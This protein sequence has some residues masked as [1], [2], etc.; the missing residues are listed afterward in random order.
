MLKEILNEFNFDGNIVNIESNNQGNINTTYV[1]TVDNGRKYLLQK[2]N[3]SVFTN[4]YVVMNN[5][6]IVTDTMEKSKVI[7]KPLKVIS[8]KKNSPLAVIKNGHGEMEYYRC[9]EYIENCISYDTVKDA[10]NPNDI[11]YNAG[12][13]FGLFHKSLTSLNSSNDVIQETIP[14]FHNTPKRFDD[15]INS[16]K[17]NIVGRSLDYPRETVDLIVKSEECFSI[18]KK[19]GKQIPI[20]VTHNDTKL[21]NV[22]ID[23]DT[24][25]VVSVVDFDTLMNGSILF[26]VGDGIR[27]CCA[28]SFEDETEVDKI[29]INMDL[30]KSYLKGYLDAMYYELTNEEL[31]NIA[32]SIKTITYELAIRFF[33]DYLNGDV[34]FKIKYPNHNADRFLN[35][36][37]LLLDIEKKQNEIQDFVNMYILYEK[38]GLKKVLK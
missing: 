29:F 38:N 30:V 36:Y 19:L 21:N 34:Y 16:L 20:R 8:T 13:A 10:K 9:Y 23:K 11:A 28:N 22:L 15:F 17:L 14:N 5:I 32:L 6:K 3:T 7:K 25:E 27:S 1:V 35:Q 18:Y 37:Y 24:S 33:T 26:D 12:N 31:Q 4:P 2:I